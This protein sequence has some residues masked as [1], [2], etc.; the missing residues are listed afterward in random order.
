MNAGQLAVIRKDVRGITSNKQVLTVMLV[1]PLVLSIIVPSAV[2]LTAVLAPETVSELQTLL[3]MLPAAGAGLSRQQVIFGLVLNNIMPAETLLYSP[4]SLRQL[5]RAKI[6]A[7]FSVGMMVSCISFAAML[8]VLELEAF[9]LTGALIMP[10]A[11]WLAIML[12]ASPAISLIA[13]AVT[14]RGSA[15]AQTVEEAQQ[16]AVFL[17]FPII[18]LLI[19]QF[20]GVI[21]INSGLLW[22]LGA[23]LAAL[24]VLLMRGAAGNFTYEKLLK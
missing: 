10:G 3:D 12:L 5:F 13:I 20:T 11:G 23:V 16:R 15:K 8:L 4:L 24:D 14:V 2:V 17:I 21:L 7:G 9:F 6:L 18:A 19:G 22:G 1:V